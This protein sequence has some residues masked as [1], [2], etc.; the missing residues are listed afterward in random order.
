MGNIES[1]DDGSIT[2]TTK[3]GPRTATMVIGETAIRMPGPAPAEQLSPGNLVTVVGSENTDGGITARSILITP[4]LGVLMGAGRTGGRGG[5]GRGSTSSSGSDPSPGPTDTFN[6]ERQTGTYDGVWFAV[7]E[8]SEATFRVRE[9]LA[10]IP[11]PHHA[12]MRTTALSGDIHLDGSPS[13]I[14]VDLH[15]LS[16]N[17]RFRDRY[18]SRSM[19]PDHPLAVFTLEDVGILPG[20]LAA[21]EEI[22]TRITGVLNIRGADFPLSF[23]LTVKDGGDVI[24]ISGET[25]FTWDSLGIKPPTAGVVLTLGDEVDVRIDLTA[26]PVR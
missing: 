25:K 21:G 12:E 2:L 8:E 16:S 15:Q 17:Q 6:S 1:I 5:G 7:T 11:L 10:L 24:K 9:Q 14:Q 20:G 19:F 23:D 18:V 26:K 13:V 22:D 4:E 3:L